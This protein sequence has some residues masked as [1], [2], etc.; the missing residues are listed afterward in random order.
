M[1]KQLTIL[2]LS[3]LLLLSPYSSAVAQTTYPDN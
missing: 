2:F 3:S 1:I